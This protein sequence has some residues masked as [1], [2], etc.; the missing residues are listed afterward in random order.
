MNQQADRLSS[1]EIA[2]LWSVYINDTMSICFSKHFLAH[3]KD[4]EARPLVQKALQLSEAHVESIRA[5]FTAE[6]FPIPI[7]FSEEDVHLAAPAL[8]YD[9]FA[10]S[11]VYGMSRIA[12]MNYGAMTATVARRDVL[13]FFNGCVQ[14]SL[15][16][17]NESVELMQY[18]G[19]YDRPPKIPYP[20][21][22][23]FVQRQSFLN[24][25]MGHRRELN[26]LELAELFS[27]IERNYFGNVLLMGLAQSVKDPEV[28]S[29]LLRGK[30]LV[31]E[32]IKALNDILME[33]DLFRTVPIAVEATDSTDPVFSERMIMFLLSTLNSAAIA[34]LGHSLGVT[35][36]NDL[37]AYYIKTIS[38]VMAFAEDGFNLMIRREWLEQPPQAAD[39]KALIAPRTR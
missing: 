29:Y 10:I 22:A 21:K 1:T 24:G 26:V 4:E 2:G 33:S 34:Y 12:L 25:V 9:P 38:K 36:R 28:K 15:S 31:E 5:I 7:G 37:S 17:Y 11:F 16:L 3:V 35:S 8:Y 32:Q 6:Q 20:K 13:D 19:I 27:N 30:A 39:R 23:E 18:K 14:S